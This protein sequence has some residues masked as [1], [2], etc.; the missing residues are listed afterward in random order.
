MKQSLPSM[1]YQRSRPASALIVTALLAIAGCA[2]APPVVA[3]VAAPPVVAVKPSQVIPIAQTER[4]V[5]IVMPVEK[6]AFDFGKA[7]LS[8]PEAHE[9]LDRVAALLRDKTQARI[10]L[11]GHT[12]NVGAR[13]LNQKLSED[14]AETVRMELMRRKVTESRIGTAGFAFE[15]PVAANDS[16]AGRKENR[17]VELIVLGENVGN[18]TRGE[19]PGSFEVAFGQLKAAIESGAL[20]APKGN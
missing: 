4:G 20:R 7:T 13:A 1:L 8:A 5:L 19:P 3:P 16:E 17:R 10:Q 2:S 12:D 6:V 15:R 18:I 11:E 9:L 14:R